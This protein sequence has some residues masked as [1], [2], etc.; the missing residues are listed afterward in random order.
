MPISSLA[1]I[2]MERIFFSERDSKQ[3]V[4]FK[5]SLRSTAVSEC[6]MEW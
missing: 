2:F 6:G 4:G 5:I 1:R 3:K